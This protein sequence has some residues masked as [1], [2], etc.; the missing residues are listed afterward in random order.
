MISYAPLWQ[1]MMRK[2]VTTYTLISK[3]NI[4]P[5][6]IYQLKHNQSIT[7]HTLER[8]CRILGCTPNEVVAFVSQGEEV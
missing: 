7:M 8:I 1:T 2:N 4:N 3:Y 5:R 6:T